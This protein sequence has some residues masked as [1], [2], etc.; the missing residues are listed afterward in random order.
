MTFL[1]GFAIVWAI[2]SVVLQIILYISEKRD[3]NNWH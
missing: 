1:F 3:K 2:Y